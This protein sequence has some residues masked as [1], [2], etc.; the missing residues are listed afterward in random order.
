MTNEREGQGFTILRRGPARL[1]PSRA[2]DGSGQQPPL[3]EGLPEW[4]ELLCKKCGARF[5]AVQSPRTLVPGSFSGL[6][7]TRDVTVAC[8]TRGCQTATVSTA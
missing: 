5:Q 6:A 7:F 2:S 1:I 8:K 4:I 3:M